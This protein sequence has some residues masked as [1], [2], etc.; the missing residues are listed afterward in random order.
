VN[1]H[2]YKWLGVRASALLVVLVL[3]VLSPLSCLV[4]C[5]VLDARQ[6]TYGVAFFLCDH[7]DLVPQAQP[8]DLP[9]PLSPRAVYELVLLA[10][11]TLLLVRTTQQ[12]LRPAPVLFHP[13]QSPPPTP[14]PRSQVRLAV[15]M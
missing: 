15:A 2:P 14:P 5:A 11:M 1:G 9:A 8:T 13:W 7:G 6:H 10:L 4:H 3:A 12:L